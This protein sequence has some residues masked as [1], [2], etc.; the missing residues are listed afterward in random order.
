MRGKPLFALLVASLFVAL[1]FTAV[2]V[3]W[4][5]H[6]EGLSPDSSVTDPEGDVLELRMLSPFPYPGRDLAIEG[7]TAKAL[8]PR[9]VVGDPHSFQWVGATLKPLLQRPLDV[10]PDY[11][12]LNW[13]RG[14]TS[15]A[16]DAQDL[17]LLAYEDLTYVRLREVAPSRLEFFWRC[18][19]D[20]PLTASDFTYVVL[21]GSNLLVGSDY[22]VALIPTSTGWSWS[23]S[24]PEDTR[25][26]WDSANYEDI[27]DASVSQSGDGQLRFQMTVAQDIPAVPSDEDGYPW[28]TWM[29]DVDRD[30]APGGANDVN[31]V[32]RWNGES[33]QWEGALRGWNGQ[34]YVDLGTGV[35][36]SRT[37][38]TV[39]AT[40]G[41][42]DLGLTGGFLWQARTTV[43]V[44]PGDD[45]FTGLAD[46][47]PDSGWAEEVGP[48]PS[49]T[50]T[51]SPT[52]EPTATATETFPA[53]Q[54]RIYL[55]VITRG[56]AS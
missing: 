22:M 13:A 23:V 19:G 18:R 38:A 10:A 9:W 49:P 34:H 41:A 32:V 20:I 54:Q 11:Q 5:E 7:N 39:S 33:S 8:V 53:P 35:P 46:Y 48:L 16:P 45:Q 28:F 29:L 25:F 47:A 50:P 55:P 12:V 43:N 4:G 42:E 51:V 52:S 24:T 3:G 30:Q 31:V 36:I 17:A 15:E 37:G 1:T 2:G 44:G 56:V 26:P 14:T 21:I 27:L 6:A 40:V